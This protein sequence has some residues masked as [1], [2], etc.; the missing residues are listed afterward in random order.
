MTL[1][2]VELVY[3][4]RNATYVGE[5]VVFTTFHTIPGTHYI[6]PEIVEY[7]RSKAHA[8]ISHRSPQTV[9]KRIYLSRK[10]CK[11]RRIVNEA[12]LLARLSAFNIE[13][14]VP[15]RL[16]IEEQIQIFSNAERIVGAHVSAFANAV[17]SQFAHCIMLYPDAQN[18]I[19]K[20]QHF[21]GMMKGCGHIFKPIYHN[22]ERM[23]N[24]FNCDIDRVVH[25]VEESVFD[26]E[27]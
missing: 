9:G 19:M 5:L 26:I 7:I 8:T 25:A 16:S 3:C 20:E 17:F 15:E 1:L 6:R 22:N 24:A 11:T 27:N 12:E 21:W 13:P 2:N 10:G 14:V 18:N 4:D 23:I